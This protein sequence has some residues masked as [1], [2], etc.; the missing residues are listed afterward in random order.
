M[1][2]IFRQRRPDVA[3]VAHQQQRCHGS[4]DV[5]QTGQAALSFRWCEV[6]EALQKRRREMQPE[7]RRVHLL[8][9]H[10][11]IP[12]AGVFQRVKL[13]FLEAHH[14]PVHAHVAV[15]RARAAG[16]LR[17]F[18]FLQL[19]D[20]RVVDRVREIVAVHLPHV[21]LS[22]H[23]VETL[24]LILAGFV[25]I[26]RLFVERG[27]RGGERYLGNN[28]VGAGD[29]DDDEVIAGHRAQADSVG[30]IRIAGPVP[31]TGGVLQQ[32][33]VFTQEAAQ[34]LR[35]LLAEGFAVA[36]GQLK[37]RALQ[38]ADQDFQIIRVDVRMLRRAFKKIFGMLH[39]VL[40]Q[41]IAGRHQHR[42]RRRLPA[43]RASCPLPRGSDVARISGHHHYVQRTNVD[44]EFQRVG[45]HHGA[46]VAFAQLAFNLAPFARQVT[47]P[48]A[49]HQFPRHGTTLAC[50]AQ[51][52][53]Q[54]FHGQPVVGEYQRLLIAL[55][56]LRRD[57]PR[58]M[59]IAPADSQ[60]LVHHRRIVED[61]ILLAGRRAVALHQ[62]KR[63]F[64]ERLGQLARVGDCRRAADELRRRTIERADSFQPSQ[65]IGQMAA[66][67]A[68]VVMQLVD[69]DVAQALETFRPFRV[70]RQNAR[71]QHVRIGQHH[72]R[73]FTNGFSRVLRCVAVVGESANGKARRIHRRLE[74]VQ[75][76]FR[77]RL[78]GEQVQ[79]ARPGLV[80]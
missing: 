55:Y 41:R 51:V 58:L 35:V 45:R 52:R 17:R 48:I 2:Y 7:R 67:H 70:V 9:R 74:F 66:V 23:V 26:D 5:A 69:H 57:A 40:I 14:L 32:R 31:A 47:A 19:L 63:R 49:A 18:K 16:H 12:G 27:E 59:Q 22:P 13:H 6:R 37:S 33:G 11:Q 21:R 24:H 61:D 60:L 78:G 15:G 29:I 46:D 79:R 56:K 43:S 76:I 62:F 10:R 50:I 44:A 20:L 80:Y 4:Q 53:Q 42:E 8:F 68:T 64:G 54:H 38:M 75:L 65:H 1:R 28:I 72:A 34:F 71:V 73:A 25:Q 3:R 77:Q 30:R 39:D 36:D